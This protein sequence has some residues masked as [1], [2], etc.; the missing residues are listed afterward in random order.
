[1]KILRDHSLRHLNTFGIDAAAPWFAGVT[2]VDELLE[3]LAFARENGLPVLPLGRGSNILMAG[4]PLGLVV[5]LLIPGFAVVEDG[6]QNIRLRVGAGE[7]W[8]TLVDRCLELGLFGLENLVLIPGTAGAAPIQNIGA[9]GVEVCDVLDEVEAVEIATGRVRTFRNAE[10]GFGYRHSIFKGDLRHR[11]VVSAIVLRL[12]REPLVSASY[13][14]LAAELG[15]RGIIRPT[16]YDVAG[17]IRELRLMR[18]PDPKVLGNAGSFFENPVVDAVVAERL[19]A[20]NPD[21]PV[22]PSGNG[23]VKLAAA[24][25]IERC[26]FKGIRRGA[27]GVHPLHALVLVNHGGAT[28]RDILALAD[29]IRAAV[30][31]RFDVE[32]AI[33]PRVVG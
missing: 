24:W 25:L 19:K 33:E 26:G 21:L 23:K 22:F 2:T 6:P 8:P 15:L 16:P 4:D 18:L 14:S 9:Y 30:R 11:F 31:L 5:H 1:M 13:G 12:S 28:G 27:A 10:C 20:S 32:L 3:A 7:D 29:E 17:V